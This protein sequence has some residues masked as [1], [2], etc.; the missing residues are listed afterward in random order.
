MCC[1]ASTV[2]FSDIAS[3]IFQV[4]E[5]ER[6]MKS[7][8]VETLTKYAFSLNDNLKL[9]AKAKANEKRKNFIFFF[10]FILR[11]HSSC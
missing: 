6:I 2:N 7:S 10:S 8:Q 9:I 4:C 3:G 11:S 5:R 1:S